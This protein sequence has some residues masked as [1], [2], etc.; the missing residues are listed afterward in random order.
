MIDDRRVFIEAIRTIQPGEELT[1]DYQIGRDR[2]DPPDVDEIFACRCG[3][4]QLPR[5]DALAAA[6]RAL[7]PTT[8]RRGSS[9]GDQR[10]RAMIRPRPATV[11]GAMGVVYGDIGTSPLYA[12]EASL[13]AAGTPLDRLAVL[14]V[15]SLIF[16]SLAVVITLKYV[17]LIMR[18]D[19]E[20][21]GGILSLFA[22][23]QRTLT[24]GDPRLRWIVDAGGARRGAVLL[25][26]AD[27]ARD[28]GAER[29]RRA[30]ESQSAD[31]Q[32]GG[33]D[34]AGHHHRAV[35]DPAPRHR[36]RRPAVRPDHAAVV[37]GAG[38]LG[39]WPRCCAIRRCSRR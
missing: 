35:R 39:G 14:G 34:H 5:L 23:V 33:A 2:N 15:L 26:C 16:W 19:N 31:D 20:G 30:G 24:A 29:G 13:N 12:L 18:A 28:L 3:A 32:C 17:V 36:A 21:E 38:G 25:R 37:S 11:I 22:L 8:G 1:Y 27:H 9:G 7:A 6:A 10:N 4:E